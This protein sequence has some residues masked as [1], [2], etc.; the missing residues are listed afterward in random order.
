MQD[1]SNQ[2]ENSKNIEG[3]FIDN[4]SINS[5]NQ[6]INRNK[7]IPYNYNRE[8]QALNNL[9]QNIEQN[10]LEYFN[11][12]NQ[13]INTLPP[14]QKKIFRFENLKTKEG[15]YLILSYENNIPYNISTISLKLSNNYKNLY[16]TN[17]FIYKSFYI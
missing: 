4:E 5:N 8:Y 12:I 9:Y 11:S 6:N 3:I 14:I 13:H 7:N 16:E 2:N 15:Y 10:H 1:N 17:K